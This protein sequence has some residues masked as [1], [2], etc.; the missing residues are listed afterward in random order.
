MQDENI[1]H[2]GCTCSTAAR[3]YDDPPLYPDE[4][5]P[6]HGDIRLTATSRGYFIADFDDVCDRGPHRFDAGTVVR[7]TDGTDDTDWFEC[8]ACVDSTDI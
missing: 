2:D 6:A 4:D 1:A 5:C 8:R 7:I 3:Q